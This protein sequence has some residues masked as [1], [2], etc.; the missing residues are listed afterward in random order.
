MRYI[1]GVAPSLDSSEHQDDMTCLGSGIPINLHFPLESREGAISKWNVT[2]PWK[3][4]VSF[5]KKTSFLKEFIAYEKSNTP[6]K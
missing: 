4:L 1:L 3:L 2:A 5:K 6:R